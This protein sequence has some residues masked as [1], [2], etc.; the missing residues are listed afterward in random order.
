MAISSVTDLSIASAQSG[1]G[2]GAASQELDRESFM[3]LL[4]AELK[5]QDPLDPLQAREMVTQLSQLTS[6]EKLIS[7]E[8]GI[9][10]VQ[11]ETAGI[12]STQLSDLV[13]RNVT[14]EVKN[15]HLGQTGQATGSFELMG[16]ASKVEVT[17][18]N[19]AGDVVQVV[20]MGDTFPGVHNFNWN[21][22]D[23]EG[24][25]ASQGQYSFDV[26]ATDAN[27]LPVVV[28]T[29][30]TGRVTSVSYENGLPQLVMG[31]AKIMLGDVT[32]IAQ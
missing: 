10:A 3:K 13:G 32:S 1:V 7:I 8:S 30:L 15:V 23:A 2:R 27:G 22:S 9:S 4:V 18:R 24:N 25:R 17:I 11:A 14:A 16:R 19:A 28:G 12:A 21:G 26:R 29:Q 6:V 5:N 31:N 20:P